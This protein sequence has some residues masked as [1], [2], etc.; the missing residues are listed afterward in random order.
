[1]VDQFTVQT[2]GNTKYFLKILI[3]KEGSY[4]GCVREINL[5]SNLFL[6]LISRRSNR[7]IGSLCRL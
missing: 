1:M 4:D 6:N 3:M 7:L 5:H 2:N